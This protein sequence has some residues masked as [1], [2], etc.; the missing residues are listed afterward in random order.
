MVGVVAAKLD[1]VR[2][3]RAT[4]TIP[5][6][7]NFAIKTGALRDFLDN[8]AVMYRTAEW[9][10]GAKR[11]PP[12]SPGRP[13]LH[14]ADHLQGQ[15]AERGR[16]EAEELRAGSSFSSPQ[17]AGLSHMTVGHSKLGHFRRGNVRCRRPLMPDAIAS[18]RG[19]NI[20]E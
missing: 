19:C 6:N 8:S 18:A 11:K 4:G 9:R 14:A 17:A 3:A 2:M 1:A 10:D 15:R 20:S 7:I 16:E 12:T 13:R 5:E